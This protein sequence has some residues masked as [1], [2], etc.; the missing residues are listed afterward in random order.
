M[1]TIL[2]INP[3]TRYV[4]LAIFEGTD[5][6]YWHTRMLR[7]RWSKEKMRTVERVLLDLIEHH[8]I[9]T[10]VVKRPHS[11][12]TSRNLN[13]LVS[14]VI[15]LATKQ[16]L[17]V[18]LY[19]LDFLKEHLTPESKP[20]RVSLARHMAVRYRVLAPVLERELRLKH[21]YSLRM[22]EAVALGHLAVTSPRLRGCGKADHNR[23]RRT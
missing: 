5:L 15:R 3:G 21:Q 20:T 9:T 22:F 13:N 7:G 23:K 18:R 1:H 16:G 14:S 4:G 6:V 2:A 10:L 12:R 11:S 8:G 17:T 19:S